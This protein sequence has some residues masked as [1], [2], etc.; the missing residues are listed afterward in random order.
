[1]IC[2]ELINKELEEVLA[3]DRAGPQQLLCQ[4]ERRDNVPL[5]AGITFLIDVRDI[6][7]QKE[8]N[9]G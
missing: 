6:L 5:K 9:G 7:S 4:L 2:R 3:F 8:E 1:M